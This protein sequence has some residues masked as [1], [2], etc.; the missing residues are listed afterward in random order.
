MRYAAP[1]NTTAIT[2]S[3]GPVAVVNGV[4]ET[5]D[6]LNQGDMISLQ[7]NGFTLIPDEPVKTKATTTATTSTA[8]AD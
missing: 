7:V 4:A 1:D 6:D 2:L 8:A 3:I 5:P